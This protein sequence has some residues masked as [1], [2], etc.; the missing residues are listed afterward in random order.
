MNEAAARLRL[1]AS[2]LDAPSSSVM[3]PICAALRT[4]KMHGPCRPPSVD[5][6]GP[7]ARVKLRSLRSLRPR[8]GNAGERLAR[9]ARRALRHA[10]RDGVGAARA[11]ADAAFVFPDDRGAGTG[12][13]AH[14]ASARCKRTTRR[15][16]AKRNASVMPRP[17]ILRSPLPTRSSNTRGATIKRRSSISRPSHGAERPSTLRG[18]VASSWRASARCL[19]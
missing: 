1:R 4:A 2:I 5:R 10:V 13:R 3:P 19:R 16:P 17:E 7:T 15:K 12:D 11:E 8:G 6:Y 18:S 9:A 14:G